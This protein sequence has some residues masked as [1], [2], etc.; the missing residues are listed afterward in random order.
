MAYIVPYVRHLVDK[1]DKTEHQAFEL[2]F[3]GEQRCHG[4]IR[5]GEEDALPRDDRKATCRPLED[6]PENLATLA[7]EA[8]D[9]KAGPGPFTQ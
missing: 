3:Y 5:F 6:Q 2:G 9:T 4:G 1:D 8:P 7:L